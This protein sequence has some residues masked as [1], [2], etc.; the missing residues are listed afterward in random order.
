MIGHLR[1]GTPCCPTSRPALRGLPGFD[2]LRSG[3]TQ[4]SDL[5]VERVMSHHS[6]ES[7][8]VGERT[9]QAVRS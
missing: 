7:I 3:N 4:R 5:A 1:E 9:H 2:A 8:D 6:V